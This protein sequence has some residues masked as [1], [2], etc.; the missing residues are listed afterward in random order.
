MGRSIMVFFPHLAS[1]R[2]KKRLDMVFHGGPPVFFS[3]QLHP[4]FIP[5]PLPDGKLRIQQTVVSSIS[6]GASE[7]KM[8]L[9]SITDMT[10]PVG[11][12]KE[13]S[14]L[15]EQALEEIEK[16]KKVEEA[17][18]K[19]KDDAEAANRAK[20]E[21]LANMSHEIRTPMNGVMGM[22]S[23]LLGTHLTQEQREYAETMRTS[24]DALLSVINDILDFSRIEA[25]K[26]Q[27]ENINFDLR[28]ALEETSEIL[29]LHAHEKGLEFVSLVEPEVPSLLVGDPGRL[30]QVI[31]NLVGNAVKF[32][33]SGEIVVCV[34]LEHEDVSCAELR[35]TVSDTGI[36]IPREQQCL[37]FDAFT[38]ADPTTTRKYGGSG[39]GLAICKQLTTM[40]QGS[41]GVESEEGRGSNF[42]FTARFKKQPPRT[43]PPEDVDINLASERILVV[44]GIAGSRKLLTQM[45]DGWYCDSREVEHADT[46]ME[47]LQT[48]A[49]AGEPFSIVI[50]DKFIPGME[51]EIFGKKVK[52]DPL[53]EETHIVMLTSL[54][55]QGDVARLKEIGFSAYLTKPVRKVQLYDCLVTV[56]KRNIQTVDTTPGQLVTRFTLTEER[57]HKYRILLAEDNL[58][59]RKVATSILEKLGYWADAVVNGKEALEVM[60][61]TDYALILMDCQMPEMDGYEASLK[62]R[63]TE[64]EKKISGR[65]VSRIPIIALTA[66]AMK[67]DKE[68]CL[69]A[70]MDDYIA[71]PVDPQELTDKIEKWLNDTDKPKAGDVAIVE[72]RDPMPEVFDRP[73]LLDRI[74]GDEELLK[75]ILETFVPDADNIITLLKEALGKQDFSELANHAHALKGA[76]AN[77][78]AFALGEVAAEMEAAGTEE[79]FEKTKALMPRLLEQLEALK[80]ELR[81]ASLIED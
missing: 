70:G 44:G 36:G 14:L 75:N 26:L 18:K 30:R 71:K 56:L 32:T 28:T 33:S 72:D 39:L 62:I 5:T 37:L 1:N 57:R 81:S 60:E 45:L 24:G 21:F 59:N 65:P 9:V 42:W 67:G 76:A 77:I 31:I 2:Y 78:N 20:S 27:L 3:P 80:S 48:A 17:L 40:M 41:I 69:A 4:H 34:S 55:R 51:G 8:L 63:E 25:G 49:E 74:M 29:A 11:Q 35:F 50:V 79:D 68:K 38:Q 54:G 7:E 66:H 19:A 23:L 46:A 6:S 52:K 53:L 61:K 58:T 47:L 64:K 43:I 12:L 22:T 15:R 73:G 10:L 16:R 13:I